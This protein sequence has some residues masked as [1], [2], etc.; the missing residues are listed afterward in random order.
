MWLCAKGWL[1]LPWESVKF[2]DGVAVRRKFRRFPHQGI[3]GPV[4]GTRT[5]VDEPTKIKSVAGVFSLGAR[6]EGEWV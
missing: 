1:S 4:G 6:Q 5:V 2:L 3:T